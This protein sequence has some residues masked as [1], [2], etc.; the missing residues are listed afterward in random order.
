MGEGRV[1]VGVTGAAWVP[2]DSQRRCICV[3]KK[4]RPRGGISSRR[5]CPM[6]GSVWIAGS[7][8]KRN[9]PCHARPAAGLAPG[10]SLRISIRGRRVT[11]PPSRPV[12][13]RLVAAPVSGDARRAAGRGSRIRTP[14]P[15]PSRCA[16]ALRSGQELRKP[17]ENAGAWGCSA[18]GRGRR[19]HASSYPAIASR[20]VSAN[21]S[22]L[23]WPTPKTSANCAR[24]MGRRAAMSTRVLSEKM[25]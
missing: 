5:N 4:K 20:K 12:A 22:S 10:E 9:G 13:I 25:T 14:V 1:R 19:R 6:M 16:L 18:G 17:A 8:F 11:D 21:C 15:P 3:V 2:R 24:S 23:A 7:T